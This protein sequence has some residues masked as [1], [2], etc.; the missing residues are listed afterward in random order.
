VV[1]G[2]VAGLAGCTA[3]E[4][5]APKVTVSVKASPTGLAAGAG[6][7][8]SGSYRFKVVANEGAY[9]GS[10]DPVG[11]VLDASV[12]VRSGEQALKIDTV[13]VRGVAYTRLTGLPLPGFDGGTWYR[14]DP[15][16]VTRPGALGLSAIKD[17]TGVQALVA[18]THD[19]RRDGRTYRGTVDMTRVVAW[20]PVNV[21]QVMQLG[22][23]AKAIPFEAVVDERDRI[24]SV[25]V[26]I[27]NNT[28]EAT[29][30]DFGAAVSV[31][32]P[33][34]AQPLPD[35]LYGMLGL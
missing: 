12:N 24:T 25:K 10:I 18:A 17:P 26:S 2:V 32:E 27:P 33:K 14:V 35:H 15:Q 4:K 30:S 20:G 7:L 3:G 9:T 22:E 5:A 19:V 21:G 28:V 31:D 23:A 13:E 16:R 1:L 29:Y 6:V 11:D 34:D 8:A